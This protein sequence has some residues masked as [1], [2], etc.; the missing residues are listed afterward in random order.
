MKSYFKF[1]LQGSALLPIWLCYLVFILSRYLPI[2]YQ[3]KIISPPDISAVWAFSISMSFLVIALV[4]MF[5]VTK[6][7]IENV[8]V[9]GQTFHFKASIL[10]FIGLLFLNLLL[11]IST[12]FIYTPWAIRSFHRF[13]SGSISYNDG[14]FNFMGRGSYLL[15]IFIFGLIVPVFIAS[16]A[17][18]HFFTGDV[19]FTAG[20]VNMEQLNKIG[21]SYQIIMAFVVIPYTYLFYNWLFNFTYKNYFINWEVDFWLG[22]G[23]IFKEL[24]LSII[25]LGIYIPMALLNLYKYFIER[26]VMQSGEGS[27]SFGFDLDAKKDYVFVLKQT[28]LSIVTL[29]FYY[30]W[31]ICKVG[32]LV[33]G[34]TFALSE[35][36]ETPKMEEVLEPELLD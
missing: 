29:G 4:L 2:L 27:H 26:T 28:L 1:N 22:C 16:S 14:N 36:D 30:P 19:F 9:K 13:F 8:E 17:I 15:L 34:K 3:F 20:K 6:L 7:I 33:L 12:L 35:I 32:A 25:T 31:A 23:K 18:M 24:F 21:Y 11:I 5:Y 10:R